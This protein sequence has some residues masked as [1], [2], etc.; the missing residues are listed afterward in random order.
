MN[1]WN[2]IK[3]MFNQDPIIKESTKKVDLKD[4]PTPTIVNKKEI[5][6]NK[7]KFEKAMKFIRVVEGG[8]FFHPNDP[9]GFTNMGLTQRDYPNLDL[10]NLTRKQADEIFYKDYWQKSSA[11]H[12][13]YPAY[14][15]YF[16][17]VVNTGTSRANKILQGILGVEQDGIVGALTLKKL[18]DVDPKELAINLA[19]GKQKFYVNLSAKNSRYRPFMRGWTRRTNA[20]KE[21]ITKGD[22]AW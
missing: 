20:L 12:L 13:P 8:K 4:I 17:A 9:G 7:E 16:D 19:D 15:S 22:F 11:T 10:H 2:I 14:I 5:E 21:Y 18:K 6:K 3:K 1:I